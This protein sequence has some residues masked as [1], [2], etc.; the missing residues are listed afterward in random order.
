VRY[1]VT[2]SMVAAQPTA[3]IRAETTWERFPALWGELLSE[4]WD[5]VRSNAAIAPGRNVMLYLDDVPN[6]EIGAEAAGPFEP[7]GRVVPS[8]L[9]SGR[10]ATALHRGS[11]L[12]IGEAH[13]AVKAWCEEHGL[14]RAG[15]CWEIYGHAVP[16]EADQE[17]EVYWLLR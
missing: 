1:E 11:Y 15:P 7:I 3:V 14:E 10:V 2:E 4:V 17:V 5:V 13:D 6:V 8:A 16:N 9:P 12:R